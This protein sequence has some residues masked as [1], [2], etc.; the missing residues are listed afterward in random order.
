MKLLTSAAADERMEALRTLALA[1]LAQP[2]KAD[3]L[4]HGLSD[5]DAA[6]RAEA[7]GLLTALGADPDISAAIIALNHDDPSRRQVG[8]DRLIK[9]LKQPLSEMDVGA[10]AVCVIAMLKSAER[11]EDLKGL[12]PHLLDVLAGCAAAVGRN[13]ERLAEVIRILMNLVASTAKR[14]MA[15]RDVDALLSPAYRLMS[16]LATA[17]PQTLLPVLEAERKR[18][19]DALSESLLL[20]TMLDLIPI[21]SPEEDEFIE[22]AAAFLARDTEE[23][24]DSRA[25]GVRMVRRGEKS[26]VALC[27]HFERATP[28]GQKYL[29]LLLD[30]I[31]R[32]HTISPPAIE[33]AGAVLLHTIEAGGKGIRMSAMECRFACDANISEELRGKLSR[34]FLECINDFTFNFDV[35]KIESTISRMGLAALAPLLER[36]SGERS[37]EERVRAVRLLGELSLN[38]RAPRGQLSRLQEGITD[39]LRQLQAISLDPLFAARGELLCALGKV[40]SSPAASKEADAVIT[41]TLLDAAR[42]DDA[43]V[44]PQALEGLS[45]VAGSRRAQPDMIHATSELL[46]H[47]LEGLVLDITSDERRVDGETVLEITGGEKYTNVLPVLIAGMTRIACSSSC[48][49]VI[50]R[51]LAQTLIGRWKKIGAGELIWGPSNTLL[52]IE[53]L[54]NLGCHKSF[55]PELR[56]EILR[57]FAPKH[58]QTRIMHAL[59]EILASDD[60]AATA[61]GAVTIGYAIL[62][63]RGKDSQFSAEDR[64]DI[65]RALARI[66]GRATLGGPALEQQQKSTS[67]R[68]MILEEIFKGLKDMV[69]GSFEALVS[70]RENPK[71]PKELRVDI[72]RRLREYSSLATR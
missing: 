12:T 9:L 61:V 43:R 57:S 16:A 30:D 25:I 51:D 18:S 35:E 27:Q 56:L 31:C 66:L 2:E 34:V 70:L 63:R 50:M 46:R 24:R 19:S 38:M 49:P 7:A 22:T 11:G 29:L 60:T 1:P 72:E 3:V 59:T 8:V 32:M 6:V 44:V 53:G 17:V 64:E 5:R 33:R 28:G 36:L 41:R 37:P 71:I 58:V 54:K 40:V 39:M 10:V 13:P 4:L 65:L 26:L 48:P 69:P 68:R 55:P 67:L 62:G 21:G 47:V 14:G 42:G 20:Q 52:L 15:S 45:Y 23:G